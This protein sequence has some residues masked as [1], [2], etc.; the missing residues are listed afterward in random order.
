MVNLS[1]FRISISPISPGNL[2]LTGEKRVK[3]NF[4]KYSSDNDRFRGERST[5]NAKYFFLFLAVSP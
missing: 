2:L 5:R 3:L 1:K 4:T